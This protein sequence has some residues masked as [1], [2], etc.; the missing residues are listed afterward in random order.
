MAGLIFSVNPSFSED[1]C[2]QIGEIQE[3]GLSP[4]Q[5]TEEARSGEMETRL[6]LAT[7]NRAAS[8]LTQ[9]LGFVVVGR[10]KRYYPDGDEASLLSR[11]T[12]SP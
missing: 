2:I 3:V 1:V 8:Q 12:A 10:R 6:E 11:P 4:S 9:G 5:T 7:A